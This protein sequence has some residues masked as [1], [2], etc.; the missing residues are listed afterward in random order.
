VSEKDV[1]HDWPAG[2]SGTPNS[3]TVQA[4]GPIWSPNT[5]SG[6]AEKALAKQITSARNTVDFESDELSDPASYQALAAD[7]TRGVRC[8]VVM[9]RSSEWDSAFRA[10][11]KAGCL[12]DVFPDSSTALYIHEKL[13]LDD[14]STTRES[15]LIG[16]EN[17]SVTSLTRNRELAIL[18]TA[19]DGG[20]AAIA[21]AKGRLIPLRD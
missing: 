15:L 4:S 3:Q 5:G 14:R 18:L 17:G 21:T 13:I 6:T 10:I 20:G 19:A 7:A 1:S 9:T 12:V 2:V 11:T 16:S 8:R